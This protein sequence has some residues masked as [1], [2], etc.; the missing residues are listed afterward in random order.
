[1]KI[2]TLYCLLLCAAFVLPG[3]ATYQP[4][5]LSALRR[6]IEQKPPPRDFVF[7][8]ELAAKILALDP[9]HV[10][11][12]DVKDV[13]SHAPAPQI[14][15]IHGGIYPVYL[16]MKSFSEFLIGMGYPEASIRNPGNG[17]Y[18]FSCYSSSEK[19][20]GAI[21]WYYERDGMRPMIVGHSQGGMQAV[22]VL[23][24]LAGDS[25]K[26]IHV[27]DPLIQQTESRCYIID[28]LTGK[29]RPVVG[30][31]LSY[32]TALC[33]GGL[34]RI[35]P[36]Q[37]DV[38][39]DLRE[40]PNSVVEFTGFYLHNDLLGGDYLGYGPANCYKATGTA[41]VRNVRLPKSYNHVTIPDTKHLLDSQE[42]MDWI[43]NYAPTNRPEL[44]MKFKS[45]TSNILWA[46]D[47]WH[48]IKKYW[49]IEL[50]RLIRAQETKQN[51]R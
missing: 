37:W 28:P 16:D 10:T 30:L 41:I 14:V 34:T 22:K 7:S 32:V 29:K 51:G 4:Q 3:C 49:V 6:Q 15:N 11:G 35:L 24:E 18:S 42:V 23:H 2:K 19:I 26:E 43:N 8:P 38:D 47:V 12:K 39:G 45:D 1:M 17:S 5:G 27:W 44:T 40:I 20:A 25:T 50:Q 13:L 33:A 36:N 31:Q 9:D 48:D 21:A 46:A